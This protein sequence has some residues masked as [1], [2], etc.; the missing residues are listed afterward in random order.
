MEPE[1]GN[2]VSFSPTA[3]Q[4]NM[5][6]LGFALIGLLTTKNTPQ[7]TPLNLCCFNK[8]LHFISDEGSHLTHSKHTK[9]NTCGARLPS[10]C[11]ATSSLLL[12]TKHLPQSTTDAVSYAC[13]PTCAHTNNNNAGGAAVAEW[14]QSNLQS[15]V[16]SNWSGSSPEADITEAYLQADSKL[17]VAK[18]FMGMGALLFLVVNIFL[19]YFC[20]CNCRKEREWVACSITCCCPKSSCAAA[21][22]SFCYAMCVCALSTTNHD[23]T[24][25]LTNHATPK[26]THT[27][28]LLPPKNRRAWHWWQ[29]VWCDS[30]ECV[31]VQGAG[32]HHPAADQQCG[33]RTHSVDTQRQGCLSHRGARARQVSV[34]RQGWGLVCT[35]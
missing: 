7:P 5:Q 18:G 17:L 12:T 24:D 16:N 6:P 23:S 32:R 22:R 33:R 13:V 10:G 15:V 31:D 14:L 19:C 35:C 3:Q 11:R 27:I 29:Q 26:K 4:S 25:W 2:L 8:T 28:T 1:T 30:R 21:L 9:H 34:C 20:V